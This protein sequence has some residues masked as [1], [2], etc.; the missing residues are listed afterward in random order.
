M[1]AEVVIPWQ[2]GCPHREAALEWVRGRWDAAGF[3]S[4]VGTTEGPWCK[5]AAVADGLTR[6]TADVVIV[7]DADV[8][9]DGITDAVAQVDAHG[10]AVPHR[11]VHRL[12]A[13][14]TAAVLAGSDWHGL[15]LSRDNA[16][17]RRP[18]EGYRAGGIVVLRRDVIDTVPLDRKFVG[19]GGEDEAW[20]MALTLLIGEPWQGDADL[21]HLWH[22]PQQRMTRTRGSRDSQGLLAAY[23]RA[24]R[25]PEE[26]RALVEEGR[27]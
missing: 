19:W 21:V 3:P 13:D 5:A 14:S 22:P 15:P 24:R 11:L 25:S 10:W 26:M 12:S 8:W 6:T 1:T 7:S 16:R 18:Y 27:P 20:S 2:A 4:V 9:C 17:D 23:R